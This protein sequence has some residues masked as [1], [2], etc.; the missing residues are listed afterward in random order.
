TGLDPGSPT[1]TSITLIWRE[2]TGAA[3]YEVE[4]SEEGGSF[5]PAN[6]GSET[7][8]ST[9]TDTQCIASG[10]DE[11]TAYRFQ[12]KAFPDSADTT[13]EES[14][15]SVPSASVET[16]GVV[17]PP[18][19]TETSELNLRWKSDGTSITWDWE[20]V[21]DRELRERTEHLVQ[22]I[23]AQGGSCADIDYPGAD[24]D[25]R[26]WTDADNTGWKSRGKN[27]SLTRG[28]VSGAELGAGAVRGLCVVRTWL[29]ELANDVKVRA[30]G[31][32]ELV[33]ASTVPSSTA[34]ATDAPN[35]EVRT[36]ETKRTTTFLEWTYEA[37]AGFRYPGRL[38]SVTGD[39]EDPTCENGGEAVTSTTAAPRS[40]SSRH[41]EDR[42]LK[43][44]RKYALCL[45]AVN[46]YGASELAAI[47]DGGTDGDG[48]RTTLPAAPKSV[49]YS[50]TDSW[51]IKHPTGTDRVRRLVW[52]VPTTEGTPDMASKF[53]S[54]VIL[55][56]K[57]SI[58]SAACA[59]SGN[60]AAD[61]VLSDSIEYVRIPSDSEQVA[62]S[63][64]STGF[65]VVA[66]HDTDLLT[67]TGG[68]TAA[69]SYYV[70][71]CVRADPDGVANSGNDHGPWKISPAKSFVRTAPA[72]PSRFTVQPDYTGANNPVMTL[73]W[74]AVG[75]ADTYEVEVQTRTRQ[76]VDDG[77][78]G[79]ETAY[80]NFGSW[81]DWTSGSSPCDTDG[82]A[83]R[84]CEWSGG[85]YDEEPSTGRD[86]QHASQF[87][88]R[89]TASDT[90]VG[91]GGLM[92]K[93]SNWTTID[94]PRAPSQ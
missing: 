72:V 47:G 66:T 19:V 35:P 14:L 17:R 87:R 37:E 36:D 38:V 60:A 93:W 29:N 30:Y 28:S 86:T 90:E 9:V 31:A 70:Y 8:G 4:Q 78:L 26:D 44:Y 94:H 7:G 77:T 68:A 91:A 43:T 2:V 61:N 59:T 82:L 13:R 73:T 18:V 79:T 76:E 3:S 48:V 12:V 15:W 24:V 62:S 23:T 75:A 16:T 50:T 69:G 21:E 80:S 56:T 57:N 92:G 11:R 42:R 84:R 58:Q 10:L 20:P 46:D 55:S 63:D 64:T 45:Q 52:E 40:G 81:G 27:I 6:C 39:D 49:N 32:P 51:V 65:E 41:R 54:R 5:E 67:I 83:A 1:R 71:T 74:N 34:D 89:A 88:I 22:V 85:S 53:D 25:G 33:W